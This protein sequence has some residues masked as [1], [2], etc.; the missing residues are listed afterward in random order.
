MF[1]IKQ[2]PRLPPFRAEVHVDGDQV[3]L[4]IRH[5]F[6]FLVMATVFAAI[7]AVMSLDMAA[8]TAV[9]PYAKW[10]LLFSVLLAIH[11][12]RLGLSKQDWRIDLS[13]KFVIYRGP[14]WLFGS[15]GVPVMI[16]RVEIV[17][18]TIRRWRV[19]PGVNPW[20][21]HA[22][23][24]RGE[25]QKYWI[26]AVEEHA[27]ALTDWAREWAPDDWVRRSK[28]WLIVQTLL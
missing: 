15:L 9:I 23:V 13:H 18:I 22:V 27:P 12:T 21:T 1:A 11:F 8:S 28:D 10:F 3:L 14:A 6:F 19:R 20:E 16:D 24:I 2:I 7:A 4:R 26:V 17:P 5:N 25:K